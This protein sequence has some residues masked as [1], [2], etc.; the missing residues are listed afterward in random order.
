METHFDIEEFFC[1]HCGHRWVL[2]SDEEITD[3]QHNK[4]LEEALKEHELK[5]MEGE[6]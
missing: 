3:E 5:E 6:L 4:W 2:L 1:L